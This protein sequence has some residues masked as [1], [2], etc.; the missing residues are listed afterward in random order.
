[1]KIDNLVSVLIDIE[2]VSYNFILKSLI[3]LPQNICLKL[4]FY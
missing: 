1:M 4:L 2:V 3:F